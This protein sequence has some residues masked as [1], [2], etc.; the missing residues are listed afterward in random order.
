MKI[1][2][3]NVKETQK[4]GQK[5]GQIIKNIS[6]NLD[7]AFVISLEG[8]LGGGKTSFMQGFAKGLNLNQKILSPTF[9]I[10]RQYDLSVASFESLYHCDYYRLD[11]EENKEVGFDSFF[12]NPQNL[13]VVEWGDKIKSILPEKRLTIKFDFKGKEKRVITIIDPFKIIDFLNNEPIRS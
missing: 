7:T 11:Q 10:C 5:I 9:I 12:A 8:D 6:L 4:I 2:T 3:N 13:V 1:V